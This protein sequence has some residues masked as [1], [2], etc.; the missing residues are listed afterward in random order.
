VFSFLVTVTVRGK[1]NSALTLTVP[2]GIVNVVVLEE[3]SARVIEVL[4]VST[5]HRIKDCPEF[6]VA[7]SVT[8]VPGATAMLEPADMDEVRALAVPLP[9]V[10]TLTVLDWAKL[11][12]M[13]TAVFGI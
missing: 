1:P 11:A 13:V 8:V 5:T 9:L 4:P 7:V 10:V 3:S 2:Y 6:G 12:L